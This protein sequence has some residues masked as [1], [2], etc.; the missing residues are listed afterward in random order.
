M[1]YKIGTLEEYLSENP[2]PEKEEDKPQ[3]RNWKNPKKDNQYLWQSPNGTIEENEKFNI[4][5]V[6]QSAIIHPTFTKYYINKNGEYRA[7][8][9]RAKESMQSGLKNLEIFDSKDEWIDRI[10]FLKIKKEDIE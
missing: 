10:N 3:L 5:S 6:W 1:K 4:I 7:G 8:I 9:V 2:R